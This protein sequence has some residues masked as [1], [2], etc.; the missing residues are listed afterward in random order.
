MIDRH[1]FYILGWLRQICTEVT[2]MSVRLPVIITFQCRKVAVE[3]LNIM[4]LIFSV[5]INVQIYSARARHERGVLSVPCKVSP[6]R[7]LNHTTGS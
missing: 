3:V 4:S 6:I 5:L 7:V 1:F 2:V